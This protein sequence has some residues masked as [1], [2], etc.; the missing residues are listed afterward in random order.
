MTELSAK[1]IPTT[2]SKL[3]D[4]E[5]RKF[6]KLAAAKSAA[7][8]MIRPSEDEKEANRICFAS[9]GSPTDEI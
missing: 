5:I 8:E 1:N 6:R 9:D 7:I 2:T 4:S 3:R